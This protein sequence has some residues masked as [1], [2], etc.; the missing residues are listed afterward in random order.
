MTMKKI[1]KKCLP[2][3]DVLLIPFVYTSSLLLYLIRTVGVERMKIS[4]WIFR[5]VG[6]FPIRDHYYEPLFDPVHLRQPLSKD[7]LLI[8]IDLNTE[9]Q[10]KILDQFGFREELSTVPLEQ[11]ND[12]KFFYHNRFFS[13]GD[14]EY[15]YSLVRLIMPRRIIEIGG[16]FSTLIAMKA[17][18]KNRAE[19]SNYSC[20]YTCIEPFGCIELEKL[21]VRVIKK[22]VERV[23]PSFFSSLERNDI[24][25]IDSSHMIRPQGDVVFAYLEVLPLLKQ[26]VIIHLHDIFTPK[27]YPDEWVLDEIRLWN[28]QYL[29]EAFLTLNR[30]FKVIGALNY[31][32]HHYFEELSRKCPMLKLEP[33]SE[34]RSFYIVRV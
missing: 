26:G 29:L 14:A 23:A 25:F 28:E 15:W 8:G 16:G 17:I 11:E 2:L 30:E 22:R 12:S 31:L 33:H 32:K 34:P 21:G 4:R 20:E 19:N 18:V 10:L 24:L 9:E 3:F 27:D 13:V 6:V 1:L 7:R 5:K